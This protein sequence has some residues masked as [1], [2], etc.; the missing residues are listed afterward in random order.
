MYSATFTN[1]F[2][3]SKGA[4]IQSCISIFQQPPAIFT[5]VFV[6]FLFTAIQPNHNA[7]DILLSFNTCH[8]FSTTIKSVLA[9]N[10]SDDQNPAPRMDDKR[11]RFRSHS[12]SISFFCILSVKRQEL[13][14]CIPGKQ[15]L[16]FA[17]LLNDIFK[18][19]RN[20]AKL[21]E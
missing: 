3:F 19:F 21:P 10:S 12:L 11:Y 15:T 17:L 2:L 13:P 14:L 8:S 20:L 18:F 5:T 4:T 16:N 6:P 1:C 9:Q 7:Y